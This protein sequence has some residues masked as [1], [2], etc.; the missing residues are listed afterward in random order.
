MIGITVKS[1]LFILLNILAVGYLV[2]GYIVDP[3]PAIVATKGSYKF[4]ISFEYA[5]GI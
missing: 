4:I 5:L 2:D 3:G 1:C